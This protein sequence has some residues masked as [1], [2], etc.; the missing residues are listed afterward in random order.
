[1]PLST[2][3]RPSSR[4]FSGTT[5]A[6]SRRAFSASFSARSLLV[7]PMTPIR[8]PARSLSPWAGVLDFTSRP[9]PSTKMKLEKS[10]VFMRPSV[11][12]LEPHSRSA[13]PLATA[14]KR[15]STVTGT[16]FTCSAPAPSCSSIAVTTRRQR[17][18]L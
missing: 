13:R 7:P 5:V 8:L 16:Q 14:S 12:V 6:L 18:T 4:D 17:S 15:L 11:T 2:C 1:M 10:T 9:V 3:V